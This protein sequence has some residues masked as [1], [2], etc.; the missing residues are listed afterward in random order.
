MTP[1]VGIFEGIEA[2]AYEIEPLHAAAVRTRVLARRNGSAGNG[3]SDEAAVEA[4][5]VAI[6]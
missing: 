3:W 4:R 1:R 5:K 2:V 6:S